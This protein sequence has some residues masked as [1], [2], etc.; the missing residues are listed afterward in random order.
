[1]CTFE[2]Q[3]TDTVGD[4]QLDK[5]LSELGATGLFTTSLEQELVSRTTRLAV[6]SLKDMPTTLPAGL[7]LGAIGKRENPQDGVVFHPIHR[8]AGIRSLAQLA[9]GSVVGTSSLR[10]EAL[11]HQ[12]YP[13][14]VIKTIRGNIQTRLRKCHQEIASG[15]L[16]PGRFGY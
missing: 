7:N 4:Q 12:Q 5:H 11:V 13:D 15:G 9:P 16:R 10:R 8:Q 14:L 1:M 3:L 2:I 6:H